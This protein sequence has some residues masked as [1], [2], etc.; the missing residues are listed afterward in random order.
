MA[1][2]GNGRGW[3][4]PDVGNTLKGGYVYPDLQEAGS[5]RPLPP[6]SHGEAGLFWSLA[7]PLSC[8]GH[9]MVSLRLSFLAREMAFIRMHA[10]KSRQNLDFFFIFMSLEQSVIMF[11]FPCWVN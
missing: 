5:W 2:R 1:W 10:T 7:V 3:D 4:R 6:S 8:C 11:F 9:E